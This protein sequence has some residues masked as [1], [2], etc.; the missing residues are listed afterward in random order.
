[1]SDDQGYFFLNG[2][3]MGQGY[4]VRRLNPGYYTLTE[5]QP[6]NGRICKSQTIQIDSC[7]TTTVKWDFWCR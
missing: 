3:Y 4:F 2:V 1:M 5:T 7:K 6:S